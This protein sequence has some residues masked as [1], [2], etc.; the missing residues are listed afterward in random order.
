MMREYACQRSYKGDR[1]TG[2]GQTH[3]RST[4]CL[5][6]LLATQIRMSPMILVF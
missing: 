1:S 4:L 6:T 2:A 5:V 3:V